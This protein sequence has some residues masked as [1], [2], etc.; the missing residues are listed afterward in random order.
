MFGI[1]MARRTVVW[2]MDRVEG[3]SAAMHALMRSR[4][5]GAGLREAEEL[6]AEEPFVFLG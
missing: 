5:G 2:V 1:Q 3:D 4:K 6:D